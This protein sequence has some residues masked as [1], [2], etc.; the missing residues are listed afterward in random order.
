[1]LITVIDS[2]NTMDLAELPDTSNLT[3]NDDLK[4]IASTI[5]QVCK[6]KLRTEGEDIDLFTLK[7]VAK[8]ALDVQKAFFDNKST[9]VQVNNVNISNNQLNYFKGIMKNEI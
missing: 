3:L 8:V 5:V 1:M 9:N 7:E 6:C 2:F 4:S